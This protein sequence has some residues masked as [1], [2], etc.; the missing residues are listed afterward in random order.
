MNQEYWPAI[1]F[2]GLMVEQA[3][4]AENLLVY[5]E[6]EIWSLLR[7]AEVTFFFLPAGADDEFAG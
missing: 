7:I 5:M 3:P 4:A 2:V 6:R 1:N